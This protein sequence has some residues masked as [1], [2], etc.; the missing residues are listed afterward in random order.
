VH[1]ETLDGHN[2]ITW[3]KTRVPNWAIPELVTQVHQYIIHM[4]RSQD[5]FQCESTDIKN[6]VAFDTFTLIS[7]PQK[8]YILGA[9]R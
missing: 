5:M 2:I 7:N 3:L 1:N 4:F 8:C 9:T 6:V